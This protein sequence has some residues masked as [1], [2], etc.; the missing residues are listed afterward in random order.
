LPDNAGT[1]PG[2]VHPIGETLSVYWD[3]AEHEEV[4][5]EVG[6]GV[7]LIKDARGEVIGFER[8]YFKSGTAPH[9]LGVVLQTVRA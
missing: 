9:E 7:M 6:Q 1:S 3:D 8:F 4:C 5:E 2:S